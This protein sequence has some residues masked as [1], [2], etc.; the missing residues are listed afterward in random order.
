MRVRESVTYH[1]IESKAAAGGKTRL[2]GYQ[3]ARL[4]VASGLGENSR[5]LAGGQRHDLLVDGVALEGLVVR[6]GE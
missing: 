4:P 3:I 2:D 5:V 6:H 1:Q